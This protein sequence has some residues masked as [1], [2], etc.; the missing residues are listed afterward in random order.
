MDIFQ[1][2]L[3]FYHVL[4]LEGNVLGGFLL[5]FRL[6]QLTHESGKKKLALACKTCDHNF[7]IYFVGRQKMALDKKVCTSPCSLLEMSII[8]KPSLTYMRGI[9]SSTFH[10]SQP[11]KAQSTRQK[12]LVLICDG[13]SFPTWAVLPQFWYCSCRKINKPNFLKA[14]GRL[15]WKLLASI[16]HTYILENFLMI[17]ISIGEHGN[18]RFY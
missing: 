5:K 2:F 11:L 7:E 1:P 3:W 18:V 4:S 12:I 10:H 16:Q 14:P 17:N 15:W 6:N 9:D 13:P 8:N